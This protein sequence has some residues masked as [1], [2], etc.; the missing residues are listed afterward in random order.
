MSIVYDGK[1]GIA[2]YD[3]VG[4][5]PTNTK[6]VAVTPKYVEDRMGSTSTGTGDGTSLTQA[7]VNALIQAALV[8]AGLIAATTNSILSIT[9]ASVNEGE[10]INHTVTL[11]LNTGGI[12]P[13]QL[14]FIN[15]ALNDILQ[16]LSF[17]NGVVLIDNFISVPNG[18]VAF[19]VA[20]TTNEDFNIEANESYILTIGGKDG[21]GTI[22]NDDFVSQAS[23]LSIS[24]V[25]AA[26]GNSLVHAVNLSDSS[27]GDFT[28]FF[29]HISTNSADINPLIM[30]SNGVSLIGVDTLRV[31]SGVALF[32]ITVNTYQ[33]TTIESD[34]SYTITLDGLTAIGTSINN[35]FLTPA[36]V[37]SVSSSVI[38]E[39]SVG[40]Y[41][42]TLNRQSIGQVFPFSFAGSASSI[43]DYSPTLTFTNGVTASSNN[44][45]VPAGVTGFNVSLNTI[46]DL[47][48]ESDENIIL[49]VGSSTGTI[50]V[51]SNDSAVPATVSSVS[52]ST[53]IEGANATFNVV[54]SKPS[55][56][57]TFTYGLSGTAEEGVDYP[58]PL[59]FTNGVTAAGNGITVP[60]GVATFSAIT[61]TSDDVVIESS[62]T[63]ILT[64]AGASGTVT[65]SDNEQIPATVETISN[66]TTTESGTLVYTVS[67]NKAS[68]GQ[69]IPISVSGSALADTDYNALF[70]YSNGVTKSGNFLVVPSGIATFI[71]S[72]LTLE[73]VA[74]ENDE[75]IIFDIG[76]AIGT[77]T[78]TNVSQ[79]PAVVQS[80]TANNA[81]EGNTITFT[82]ILDKPSIAGQVFNQTLSGT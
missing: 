46:D 65:I 68:I 81:A 31:P 27:G 16:P 14:T 20:V 82:I 71:I 11:A 10:V 6:L 33:D 9:S 51:M 79:V 72:V 13:Y 8:S 18:V 50:T 47:D 19:N 2:F 30:F 44:M 34:E 17:S 1:T 24:N 77:G 57:Q 4:P 3:G 52:S 49:T 78:I 32:T 26:E 67:L 48:I 73:D 58:V 80:I 53:I 29:N 5:A 75:T 22:V 63:I 56:G 45:S 41:T 36:D 21:V 55:I 64:I 54:L 25:S 40:V 76:G 43:T 28:Y 12:F 66:P 62:E 15:A 61:M 60:N 74:S 70:T 23:V 7:E 38:N 59:V 69:N 39:G 37:L 35:D 42:V